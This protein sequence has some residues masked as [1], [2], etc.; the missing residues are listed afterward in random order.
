MH[1]VLDDSSK[2]AVLNRL[3]DSQRVTRAQRLQTS[4]VGLQCVGDVLRQCVVG[5]LNHMHAT[6]NL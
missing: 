5:T 6:A 3:A 1:V 4:D 2:R